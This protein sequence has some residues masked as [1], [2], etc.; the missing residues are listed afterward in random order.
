[1]SIPRMISRGE[2]AE[3]AARV[4]E[5]ICEEKLEIWNFGVS[6]A[7]EA[8]VEYSDL[9]GDPRWESFAWGYL[10][11][12]AASRGEPR[13]L[14][15]TF[16]GVAA[17]RIARSHHDQQL[18]SATTELVDF[19]LARPRVHGIFRTWRRS[20][21]IQP[22]GPV[23][24]S[25]IQAGWQADPPAG[26]FLD[27]LHFEPPLFAALGRLLGRDELVE[28][29]IHEAESFIDGLQQPDGLFDHFVLHGVEGSF[30]PGWGRG[31]GWALLG[32]LDVVEALRPEDASAAAPVRASLRRLIAAMV[33]LQRPD[34]HWY[35]QV[36][37][38]ESGDEYSTA[39]FMACGF[40]RA[41]RLG[42]VS[43]D[44]VGE[45]A[46]RAVAA[47]AA[48][49]G[50]DAVLAEVSAAVMACTEPSHYANVPRGFNVPWGQGPALLA[51]VEYLKSEEAGRVG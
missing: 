24:L 32:L 25:A 2:A 38:P 10:R 12:W 47:V 34:G 37:V 8:L 44:E 31:Q 51:L 4:A 23:Q 11:A 39:A 21:L 18:V 7:F 1:M 20:P 5:T 26:A 33:G 19:L 27:C 35:A 42:V 49:I 14:D 3:L 36:H 15:C 16:P 45:A 17:V 13:E 50:A 46:D 30:G 48:G 6:V 29:A 40:R 41:V 22:Y 9:T 28:I 43:A